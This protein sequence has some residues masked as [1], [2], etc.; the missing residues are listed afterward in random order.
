MT[1]V[2]TVRPGYKVPV[3]GLYQ[4][5]DGCQYQDTFVEGKTAPATPH[6]N[7][8]WYLVQAARHRP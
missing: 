7:T 3:S 8:F 2:V 4:C 5:S 1:T 6:A